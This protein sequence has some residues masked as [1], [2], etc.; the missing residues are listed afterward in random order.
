MDNSITPISNISGSRK[1][2]LPHCS[3]ETP[4]G[5]LYPSLGFSAQEGYGTVGVRPEED[6]QDN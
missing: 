3:V 2:I 5:M 4:P 6:Q 1:R